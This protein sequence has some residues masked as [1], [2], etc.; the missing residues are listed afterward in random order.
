MVPASQLLIEFKFVFGRGNAVVVV[1]GRG[2][3]VVV[4]VVVVVVS[5]WLRSA[6]LSLP[7]IFEG[8]TGFPLKNL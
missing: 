2:N 8:F 1:F 6:D 3:A 7:F 5:L 4:V